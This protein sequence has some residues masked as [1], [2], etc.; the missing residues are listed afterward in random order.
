MSGVKL[1]ISGVSGV[2]KTT[3]AEQISKELE[4]PFIVGSSKV[5]WRKHNIVSHKDLIQKCNNDSKFAMDFQLELLEYRKEAVKG[6]NSFVT[7]RSPLDNLVYFMLQVS[8]QVSADETMAYIKACKETYPTESYGHL[9]LGMDYKMALEIPLENDG[10]RITN[11]YYQLMVQ[12]MFHMC[13]NH[14]WLDIKN[15]YGV[16]TW[17]REQRNR[18]LHNLINKVCEDKKS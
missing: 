16:T 4:I 6:L 8:Q 3:L 11:V 14:N 10:F 9:H 1:Y 13:L 18:V 2:G 12:N 7:D 15:L 5:L 17:D